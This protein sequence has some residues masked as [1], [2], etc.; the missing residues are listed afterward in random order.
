MAVTQL[1]F[2]VFVVSW[3]SLLVRWMGAVDPLIISFYRLFFSVLILAPLHLT[4][5]K[6]KKM[7][8]RRPSF[9][10][11]VAGFFLALHFITWI[12]SLQMTTVGR[13]IF[14]ESTHPLF[15]VILSALVLKERAPAHFYL[16]LLMALGGMY[17]TVHG[18]LGG[19]AH[20]LTGDL[21][22]LVSA[23]CL[24][25]YLIIARHLRAHMPLIPYLTLVYAVAAAIILFLILLKGIPLTGYSAM[26]WLLFAA[27]A[28][29]PN[30]VGHSLLNRA[31][32]Y[33]PVYR[34]NSALLA[35]SVLATSMAWMFLGET[36][37]KTFLVGALLILVSISW[38]F[39]K[40]GKANI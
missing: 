39:Y 34:V 3:G 38:I 16:P 6:R 35:E 40:E 1:L 24:A 23:L 31:S 30:L 26:T 2:A 4:Q 11:A 22:A 18:D 36:P 12:S 10:I 33:I 14:L 21:L 7:A 15:A 19:S 20:A 37:E 27:L 28:L 32:R 17:L 13:S 5:S 25:A 9:Y 8:F 29:G